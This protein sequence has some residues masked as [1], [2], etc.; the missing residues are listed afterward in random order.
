[1]P[2]ETKVSVVIFQVLRARKKQFDKKNLKD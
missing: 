1:M 2:K